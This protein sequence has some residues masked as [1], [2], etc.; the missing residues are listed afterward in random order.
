MENNPT[1]LH[2]YFLIHPPF[3]NS[4][5]QILLNIPYGKTI[6]YGDIANIIAKQKVF[7][8]ISAQAVGNAVGHNPISLII[9]CHRVVGSNGSLVG[10]AGGTDKKQQLLQLEK[11]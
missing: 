5:W 8:K 4:V 6:T 9:P 7:K 11:I 10:Y 3:R 2:L 1:L